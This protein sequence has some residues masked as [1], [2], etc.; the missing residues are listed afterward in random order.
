MK[1]I[2][3]LVTVAA[4]IALSEAFSCPTDTPTDKIVYLPHEDCHKY[5][6]CKNGTPNLRDCPN[7]E[8]GVY[9]DCPCSSAKCKMHY[10]DENIEICVKKNSSPTTACSTTPS[11]ATPSSSTAPLTTT[12]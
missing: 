9:C 3:I 10:D 8:N 12:A 2:C 11:P 5:Y 6:E 7:D 1:G 4:V